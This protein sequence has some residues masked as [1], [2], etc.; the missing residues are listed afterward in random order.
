MRVASSADIWPA[1]EG[2]LHTKLHALTDAKG[3]P[4]R[5]FMAGRQ[6]SDFVGVAAPLRSHRVRTG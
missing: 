1:H 4:I 6:V 2:G 5:F 3:C